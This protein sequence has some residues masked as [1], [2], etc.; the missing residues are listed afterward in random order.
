MSLGHTGEDKGENTGSRDGE[1]LLDLWLW[2]V[3]SFLSVCLSFL[4]VQQ[5]SEGQPR[6]SN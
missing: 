5:V 1:M 6:V 3:C 4:N 2:D